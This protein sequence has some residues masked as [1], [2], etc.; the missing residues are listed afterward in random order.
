MSSEDTVVS[1]IPS[2]IRNTL[3]GKSF[4]DSS[5]EIEMRMMK[6]R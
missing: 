6:I 4:K 1:Y 3:W 2:K 5:S